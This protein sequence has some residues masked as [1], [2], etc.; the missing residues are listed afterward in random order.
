MFLYHNMSEAATREPA[1]FRGGGAFSGRFNE[2]H[3]DHEQARQTQ[4]SGDEQHSHGVHSS[5]ISA[6]QLLHDDT[7]EDDADKPFCRICYGTDDGED[8]GYLFRP[9]KCSGSMSLIHV[10]CLGLLLL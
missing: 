10:E 3:N 5:S 2:E 9:C 8:N 1:L 7:E 4:L 6:F